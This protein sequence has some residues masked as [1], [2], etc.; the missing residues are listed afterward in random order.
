MEL[1]KR[2]IH[3]TQ[4]GKSIFDQFYLDEDYNVPDQK[5]DVSRIIQGS[6]ECRTEDIRPVENYVKV[7]GKIYFRILYMTASGVPK[8]AVL[9]GSLPFEEMVYAESDGNETYFIRGVRTEFTGTVVN[10][11][12]LSLRVMAEME[13]GRER[14][15]DEELTE[16]VE[17]EIPVYR[18]MERMN[19]LKLAV[20]RKD[21]YRIKEEII[22]PG[23]KESIVQ[24]LFADI[25]SRKLDIRLGQ[26]EIL[27]RGE[28]LVFCMYLSAD[29]KTD[30]VEQSVPYEGRSSCDGVTESMYHHIRH[31]LEDTLADIRLD[32]DG[33]M[34]ILGI[35]ATLALRM[36]IYE[37]E[38]TEVLRDMYSLEQVC[39]FDTRDVVY[40]ELLMQNQSRC[41]VTEKLSLPELRDD[42][43]QI[44]HSTGSIQVENEEYVPEGIRIEGI[45]HRSFLYLRSSDEEP[46]GSWQGM[47]PFSYL[48]EYPDMP[49]SVSD[50]LTC[51]V[52]Q[53]AVTLA[54]SEAVEVKAVLSFDVFLRR[55]L[56]VQVITEVSLS[57]QDMEQAADG[58]GIVGHIVQSGEDMWG[59]AKKYM[60]TVE[61][62]MEING[63]SDEKVSPGDK[64]LIFRENVSIL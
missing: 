28:L 19:L 42:V 61:G 59:L 18:K 7:T 8:P 50:S 13:I 46:Y 54:G 6:A 39:E 29:E 57:P 41:R 26:D 1:I 9:E 55:M 22:L 3:Y 38:A 60:T 56:T 51:H 16:D 21:T 17:S 35:E 23:T 44:I 34:R 4:E 2:P 40:E 24:V 37:E 63:L 45:L 20:S 49:G 52:E 33:E 14:L 32:E 30:W 27:L 15:R 64:L 12:K 43:L 36:N 5:D 10:S 47:V 25:G 48:I 58:P 62:I 31:S 53:L 11:R